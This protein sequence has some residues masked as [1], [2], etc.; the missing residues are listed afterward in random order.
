MDSLLWPDSE[1]IK[2]LQ[3]SG[4]GKI[5][6]KRKI[7]RRNDEGGKEGNQEEKA[8]RSKEEGKEGRVIL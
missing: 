2:S 7:L 8:E 6:Q 1:R 3:I 4:K 5:D